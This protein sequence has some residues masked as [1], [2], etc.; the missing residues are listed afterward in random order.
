MNENTNILYSRKNNKLT[1]IEL[2]KIKPVWKKTLENWNYIDVMCDEDGLY[3]G[4]VLPREH[5]F[6]IIK[7]SYLS[8]FSAI[9]GYMNGH[10]TLLPVP[11]GVFLNSINY[12]RYPKPKSIR[13]YIDI[14]WATLGLIYQ[15]WRSIGSQYH[16]K[17]ILVMFITICFF[18]VGHMLNRKSSWLGT[19]SHCVIHIGGN[20][21]NIILYSGTVPKIMNQ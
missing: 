9:Y 18:P 16:H 14:I 11:L 10:Y 8:F 19:L 2:D 17:Y 12:W 6:F 21:G 15:L 1:N 5:S 3:A 20:I 13:R 4:L 7:L